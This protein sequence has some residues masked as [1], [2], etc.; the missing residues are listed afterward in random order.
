MLAFAALNILLS[1]AHVVLHLA[2]SNGANIL[3]S[4]AANAKVDRMIDAVICMGR[5]HA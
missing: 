3:Q 5:I 4:F 1:V 2:F